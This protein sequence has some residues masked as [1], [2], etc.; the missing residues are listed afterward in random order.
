MNKPIG[1]K[2]AVDMLRLPGRRLMLMHSNSIPSGK[3]YYIVP[4]GYI[5]PADA[6]KIIARDDVIP[7]DDGMFPGVHQTWRIGSQ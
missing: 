7:G 1:L 2:K 5:D 4:G 3:A 6:E